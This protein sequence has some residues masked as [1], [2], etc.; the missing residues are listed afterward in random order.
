MRVVFL[1]FCCSV[2]FLS[3][4]AQRGYTPIVN[5]QLEGIEI[6]YKVVPK[7]FYNP[8]GQQCVVL[9]FR[10]YSDIDR[11]LSVQ[12]DLQQYEGVLMHEEYSGKM[13][14][15]AHKSRKG[16]LNGFI[17]EPEMLSHRSETKIGIEFEINEVHK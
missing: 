8:N 10:N 2:L 13:N 16:K 6:K 11:A 5:N 9:A 3:V 12:I 1:L 14:L 4:H 7:H 17:V 15:P